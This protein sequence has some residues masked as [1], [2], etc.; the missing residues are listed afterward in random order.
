MIVPDISSLSVVDSA[1]GYCI[2]NSCLLSNM[3]DQMVILTREQVEARYVSL[4]H[5]INCIVE[6][7]GP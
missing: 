6:I 1:P 3:T 2:S 7:Q 4:D 5:L